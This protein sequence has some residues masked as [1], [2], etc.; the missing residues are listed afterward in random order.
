MGDACVLLAT[1]DP[2]RLDAIDTAILATWLPVLLNAPFQYQA[3]T[4]L[5]ERLGSAF[6]A[7]V[8]QAVVSLIEEDI[9]RGHPFGIG[10]IGTY[11]SPAVEGILDRAACN[12]GATG[13]LV[14]DALQA[15]LARDEPRGAAASWDVMRRRPSH[16]PKTDATIVSDD[17]AR[18]RWDQA[19]AAAAALAYSPSLA[20]HLDQLLEELSTSADFAADVIAW[21]ERRGPGRRRPWEGLSAERKSDLLVWARRNLPREPDYPPGQVVDVR[22]VYEFPRNVT[23][24]LSGELSESAVQALHR[25]ADELDDPW[26]H[27]T[28]D[29]LAAAVRDASWAPLAPREVREILADPHRRVIITEAQLAQLLLDGL[30]VVARDIQQDANHRAAYWQRQDKPAGRTYRLT[31]PSS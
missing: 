21:T 4:L 8:D 3:S 30:D 12:R 27:R 1:T 25:A 5:I 24:M 31:S 14:L 26:L 9:T 29:D 10:R 20:T 22:A 13:H 18:R 2:T 15:L 28:A 17:Q 19:A 11:T 7:E 16:K 23:A 6:R